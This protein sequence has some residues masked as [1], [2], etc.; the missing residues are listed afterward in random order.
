MVDESRIEQSMD[1]FPTPYRRLGRGRN[2]FEWLLGHEQ[3]LNLL[4][5]LLSRVSNDFESQNA[6]NSLLRIVNKYPLLEHNYDK[7]DGLSSLRKQVITAAQKY[8]GPYTGVS[9][10]FYSMGI[11]L[12]Q[13]ARCRYVA[14]RMANM[15]KQ[16]QSSHRHQPMSMNLLELRPS[17][18][19]V[20][21]D[22]FSPN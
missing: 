4:L 10:R 20:A 16:K 15:K 18:I 21:F 14:H 9:A 22:D 11:S 6:F 1:I 2:N 8:L 19:R 5:Q 13:I 17:G 7:S 3:E 12:I